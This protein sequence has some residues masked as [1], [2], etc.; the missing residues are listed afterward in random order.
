[1]E[2]DQCARIAALCSGTSNRAWLWDCRIGLYHS[3]RSRVGITALEC[4]GGK[5]VGEGAGGKT[6]GVWRGEVDG[7]RGLGCTALA[8]AR[9][10][11]SEQPPRLELQLQ[12]QHT[13]PKQGQHEQ[14]ARNRVNVSNTILSQ[15]STQHDLQR[16]TATN[17]RNDER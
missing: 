1:M 13:K 14:C 11:A 15:R 10:D 3:D 16:T 5:V 2:N 12:L 9:G 6:H 7:S 4:R 17:F 8:R